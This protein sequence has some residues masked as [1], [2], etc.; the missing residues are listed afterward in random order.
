MS[1]G[2][3][4]PRWINSLSPVSISISSL[5]LRSCPGEIEIEG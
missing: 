4:K 3:V 1:R 2:E 5:Y